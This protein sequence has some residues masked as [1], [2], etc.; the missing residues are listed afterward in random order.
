MNFLLFSLFI[1]NCLAWKWPWDTNHLFKTGQKVDL[2]VNYAHSEVNDEQIA[3][4][5]LPSVCPPSDKSNPVHLSISEI[6][7]GDRFWQ[8]DYKLHFE[9]DNHCARICDRII[10]KKSALKVIELIKDDY[11]IEW[12]IDGLPGATTL[13][14]DDENGKPKKFY[15]KG[16]PIGFIENGIPYLHNHVMLVIRWHKEFDD[17]SKKSIV[18]F[19]IYPKSV[20][21]FH[22]PG[23]KRN[24]E[25]YKIDL[26]QD[27]LLIPYT[28][29]VFWREDTQINFNS[30]W[31]LYIDPNLNLKDNKMHWIAIVNAI[32]LI[33]LLSMFVAFIILRTIYSNNS[34]DQLSS[35]DNDDE[36][37]HWKKIPHDEIFIEPKYLSFLCI[38]SGSGIQLI[39]T[40]IGFS[41]L[42]LF[43]LNKNDKTILS[44]MIILFTIGGFFSGFSSIQQYKIFSSEP[45]TIKKAIII[46]TISATLIMILALISTIIPNFIVYSKNSPRFIKFGSLVLM[47]FIYILL[48]IPISIIGGLISLKFNYLKLIIRSNIPKTEK[49]SISKINS[50]NNNK[51]FKQDKQIYNKF[52]FNLLIFGLFPFGITFIELLFLYKSIF[53]NKISSNYLYGFIIFSGILLLIVQIENGIISTFLRLNNGD[54]SNWQWKSILISMFSILIY[55]Q[56][57]SIY[58]LFFR[59]KMIDLGSP[60]LFI[61]YSTT[62]NV[63]I[64]VAC[65]SIG[66]WSSTVFVYKLY[67][68]HKRD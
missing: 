14:D 17:P 35:S 15:I 46:S 27:K 3:Y 60:L 38:I 10:S 37:D 42:L 4:Y 68:Q 7:N 62:L 54:S 63:I 45:I 44:S 30:R 58:Y 31:K 8:S 21:D 47:F 56:I 32:V 33:S 67:C 29:S 41:I 6:L 50:N 61:V 34:N 13:I 66:I 28:Y 57:Y 59:M 2:L 53:V 5:K 36:N 52:P 40:I 65:G 11:M 26:D 48:Q 20:S 9:V 64:S 25:R 18:G 23:A 16:F 24:Y 49:L 12:V 55:L 51:K 22:C 43:G 19:E 1:S 39:F